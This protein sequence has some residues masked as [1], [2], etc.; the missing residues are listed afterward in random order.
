MEKIDKFDAWQKKLSVEHPLVY[1]L[2]LPFIFLISIRPIF[3]LILEVTFYFFLFNSISFS[4]NTVGPSM[5]PT[6]QNG[7]YVLYNPFD[8]HYEADDIIRF[9][10]YDL[11]EVLIKRVISINEVGCLWVEGDNK[12]NSTDS[13]KF[14]YVCKE[15]N[16]DFLGTVYPLK[17]IFSGF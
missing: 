8:K 13:R 6:I 10:S 3:F 16:A 9:F 11:N 14:G 15:K 12:E 1:V 4:L 17:N 7:D 2:L 5:R